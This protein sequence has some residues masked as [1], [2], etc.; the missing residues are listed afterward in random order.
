MLPGGEVEMAV[1]RDLARMPE[2]L[3]GSALAMSAV[4][5]AREI[6]GMNSATSKSMCARAL[7]DALRELRGLMPEEVVVDEVDELARR[8]ADRRAG[9]AEA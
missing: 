6:D 2:D 5:L 9:V 1:R 3:A 8:R 4:A 7:Q